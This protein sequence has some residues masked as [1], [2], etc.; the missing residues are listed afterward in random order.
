MP[1]RPE[2]RRTGALAALTLVVTALVLA[3]TVEGAGDSL[4]RTAARAWHGVFG[5][6]PKPAPEQ[7]QRVLVLI[8]APSLA[9]RMAAAEEEPTA[10]QQR[11]WNAEA[12]GAQQLLLAG[13]RERDVHVVRDQVF[14]RTFNGFSAVVS[15]R[16]LAELE[17]AHD[18]AGV[19]PVRTVYPAAPTAET[20]AGSDFQPT[21][22]RGTQVILPGFS[23]NGVT[24]ALLDSGVDRRH[25][26]LRGKVERGFDVVDGDTNV[27]PAAKPG[28][29]GVVEAHGTRMAGLV[30]GH[31]GPSGLQGVA[32]DARVLP[33]R[34]MGWQQT[35]DGSWAVLGRGD[36]LLAGL[37]RAVDPD[38]DGDVEDAVAVALVGG[39]EPYAAFASSPE[40]RATAGATALG[41][42]VVAPVGNDGRPGPGFGTVAAPAA[43]AEAIAVGTL[44]A[45]REVLEADAQLRVD[46]DTVL[47]G[48]VRV[49][50]GAALKTALRFEVASVAGATLCAARPPRWLVGSGRRSRRLL[51][52]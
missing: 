17:R 18:V 38:A 46:D 21:G 28:E 24:V 51:R 31:D 14:T 22:G 50:G 42:L 9:D 10:K 41:T 7:A 11:Q 12:E 15:P 39:V 2:G 8:S 48:P 43:A 3:G 16:A 20:I 49:L 52:H 40:A 47:D 23:G 19:F 34:V 5:D 1:R 6:R 30:V 29:P 26:Y 44:D 33:I 27:V 32:P 35:A 25:P 13:L 37:E 4:A 36:L 45:R